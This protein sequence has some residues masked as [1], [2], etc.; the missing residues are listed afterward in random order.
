[1]E[2]TEHIAAVRAGT[3]DPEALLGRFRR[4]AVLTPVV[5]EGFLSASF[6]GI[7][8]LYAFTDEPALARFVL[9]REEEPDTESEYR[10][11]LG[12]QLLDIVVPAL[13]V[14]AGV[15]LNVADEEGSMMFPPVQAVPPGEATAG[16]RT[17]R[18]TSAGERP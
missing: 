15:A 5:D 3:G 8:W 17:T 9:A 14:P 10:T 7:R 2:L 18:T 1:M 6:D 4:T 11:V 16:P 13:G 12:S